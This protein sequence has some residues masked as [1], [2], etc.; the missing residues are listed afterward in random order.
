MEFAFLIKNFSPLIAHD[1]IKESRNVNQ[2]ATHT[3]RLD[4]FVK[5]ANNV[6]GAFE[7]NRTP[8]AANYTRPWPRDSQIEEN[9]VGYRSR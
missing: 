5:L 6:S 1:E 4:T 3:S 9:L 7:D 8:E 2:L